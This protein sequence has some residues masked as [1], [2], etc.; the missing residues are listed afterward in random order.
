MR[1]PALRRDVA[2]AALVALALVAVVTP[3]LAV[4][5]LLACVVLAVCAV[6]VA[7][8]RLRNR[9]RTTRRRGPPGH[10]DS[11][12]AGGTPA[13]NGRRRLDELHGAAARASPRQ[14]SLRD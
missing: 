9:R 4:V 2:I 8:E 6:T 13:C 1:G 12:T 14:P 5:A 3:G 11:R 10:P 7:V